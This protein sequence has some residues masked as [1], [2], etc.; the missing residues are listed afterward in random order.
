MVSLDLD[1]QKFHHTERIEKPQCNPLVDQSPPPPRFIKLKFDRASK[2]NLKIASYEG[3][4]QLI[5]QILIFIQ[6]GSPISKISYSWHIEATLE[7]LKILLLN[8]RL[9]FPPIFSTQQIMWQIAW[10][11]KEILRSLYGFH[12]SWEGQILGPLRVRP[13]N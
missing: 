3:H 11:T 1:P 2:R 4:S 9:S 10:K 7:R 8:I 13:S 6:M 12:K 5:M